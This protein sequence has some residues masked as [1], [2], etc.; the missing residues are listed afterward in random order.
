MS[1]ISD[2]LKEAK[3][4]GYYVGEYGNIYS[5]KKL[6]SLR[7]NIRIEKAISAS[8]KNRKFGDNIIKNIM[9]NKNN[10]MSYSKLYEKYNT[11]KLTLS[12]LFN[13]AYYSGARNIE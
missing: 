8:S 1:N 3:S 10:S 7:K 9:N 12:Y 4:K 6:I 5:V 13:N 11:S 2:I